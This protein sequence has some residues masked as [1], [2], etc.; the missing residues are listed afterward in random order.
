MKKRYWILGGLALF[1]T[2]SL[3]FGGGSSP[4]KLCARPEAVQALNDAFVA[5]LSKLGA[6]L[7][8]DYGALGQQ[9]EAI[10]CSVSFS[11]KPLT[12]ESMKAID[13]GP[14]NAVEAAGHALVF[15]MKPNLMMHAQ[16]KPG[17]PLVQR[18]TYQVNRTL[19]DRV[20]VTVVDFP[21]LRKLR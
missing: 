9:G 17:Q 8:N 20:L 7:M 6:S 11:L 4:A 21:G 15:S 3:I 18:V 5:K 13:Q 2:V 19:D 12:S 10:V 16:T 14:Q 1:G